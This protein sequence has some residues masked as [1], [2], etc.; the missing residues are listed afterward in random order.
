M[1]KEKRDIERVITYFDFMLVS[2]PEERKAVL[3]GRD[4][5]IKKRLEKLTET[6]IRIGNEIE[7]E[8]NPETLIKTTEII[9]AIGRGFSPEI[10]FRL[11]DD[12]S[13][14]DV[15]TIK[16]SSNTIKRLLSRVIGTDGK[17]KKNIQKL[18]SASLVIYGKAIS[19]IGS[20]TE[21]ENARAAVEM[22]LAG[23]KHTT[24]WRYLEN[25]KT[26]KEDIY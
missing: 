8:G 10:A 3:I 1:A 11:M 20:Y 15:I 5:E 9:K 19:I 18:T 21:V 17:A 25:I 13:C 16:G 7:I 22:L 14:F 4:G 2:I 23:R 6:S 24:V 12:D 26:E